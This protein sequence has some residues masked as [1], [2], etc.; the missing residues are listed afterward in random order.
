MQSVTNYKCPACTGPLRYDEKTGRLVCD[1]CGS[2]F[3]VSEIESLYAEKD[4][5][6]AA[7]AMGCVMGLEP[8][9]FRATI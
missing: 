5:Q 8:T 1:Y 3:T 4:E 7:A 6:A 9:V 2:S